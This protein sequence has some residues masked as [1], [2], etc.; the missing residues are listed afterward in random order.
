M[1]FNKRTEALKADERCSKVIFVPAKRKLFAPVF[2]YA[3]IGLLLS[4]AFF[5]GCGRSSLPKESLDVA[6]HTLLVEVAADSESRRQGLMNRKSLKD[7]CGMLFVF[8]EEQKA[9]FWMKN[10]SLPLSI[11]FIAADG[12]IRQ[13]E[14]LEPYSLA[15]VVSARSVLYALEVNRGW[16]ARKGIEAGDKAIIPSKYR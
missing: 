11:A 4:A 2:S 1:N 14:D 3:V 7:E 6:G 5:S 9:S 15:P 8:E 12:T 10:T 16:F 13:I